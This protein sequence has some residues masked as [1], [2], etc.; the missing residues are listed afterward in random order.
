MGPRFLSF[1]ARGMRNISVNIWGSYST[2]VIKC[3]PI[4]TVSRTLRE[5]PPKHRQLRAP[6]P[7][8]SGNA[9]QA[10]VDPPHDG[11]SLSFAGGDARTDRSDGNT[12]VNDTVTL[13]HLDRTA[14]ALTGVQIALT[15]L[16]RELVAISDG[17]TAAHDDDRALSDVRF[18]ALES[19][20]DNLL[21]KMDATWTENTALRE[22][23]RASREETAMLKAAVE[24]LTKKLDE[25]TAM[26]APPSPGTATTSTTMQEMTMQLS[27]V[28]NDIQ[29]VLDAVRNPPGKRKRRASGQDNEPTTPT[30]RRPTTQRPRDAS[31]E[32]SLMHS[33]HATST[34]QEALDALMIKYPPRQLAIA[35]ISMEPTPSPAGPETQDTPLPDAPTTAPEKADGW[36][37][38]EG[39]ATQRRK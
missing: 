16:N 28:Q 5:M 13:G 39:K 36:K 24:T 15:K 1:T 3:F 29:D 17:E 34:A 32:H 7:K 8:A 12:V 19:K 9:F 14:T 31:P 10:L 37:T 21:Q 33:R 6:C 18:V 30:N 27:H 35:P 20:M 2:P 25:S 23:Y 22:A 26:S 11:N 38:V 4:T